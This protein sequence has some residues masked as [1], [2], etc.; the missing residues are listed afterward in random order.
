MVQGETLRVAERPM[1]WSGDEQRKGEETEPRGDKSEES[2]NSRHRLSGRKAMK[3]TETEQEGG[4]NKGRERETKSRER[5]GWG[6]K[7]IGMKLEREKEEI[8]R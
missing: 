3:T 5:D 2:W 1:F 7:D 6:G 4:R 8:E